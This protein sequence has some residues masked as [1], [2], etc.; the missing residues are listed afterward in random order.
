MQLD[1]C[2]KT[3]AKPLFQ[4]DYFSGMGS[5]NVS[6]F[7]NGDSTCKTIAIVFIVVGSLIGAYMLVVIF[8]YA[9]IGLTCIGAF[10][11]G[12]SARSR[13]EKLSSAIQRPFNNMNTYPNQ[14]PMMQMGPMNPAYPSP[15]A[16]YLPNSTGFPDNGNQGSSLQ[17]QSYPSGS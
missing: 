13:R 14:P 1:L 15:T 10:T 7:C 9:C 4:R 3:L 12:S 11:C 6:S 8:L 2:P 16:P 17:P 5:S